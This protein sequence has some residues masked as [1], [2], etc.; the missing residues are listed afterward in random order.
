M[1]PNGG[2]DPARILN[3]IEECLATVPPRDTVR[4]TMTENVAWFGRAGAAVAAWGGPSAMTFQLL[5]RELQGPRTNELA[6]PYNGI[7]TVLHQA[8]YD[9]RLR[10]GGPIGTVLESG[11]TFQYFEVVRKYL[12]Q[13]TSDAFF[14]DPYMDGTIP[15]KFLVHVPVSASIRI[16]SK[17]YKDNVPQLV[18]AAKALEAQYGRSIEVRTCDGIHDRFLFIDKARCFLSGASFKDGA[19]KTPTVL[20]E[21]IDAFAVVAAQ[22]EREWSSAKPA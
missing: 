17:V 11:Q 7:L 16:L 5:I 9:L 18:S 13:A 15:G 6:S 3:E 4:G 20:V 8:A 12:A 10:S 21:I 22:Y 2:V 19:T 14:I 1:F